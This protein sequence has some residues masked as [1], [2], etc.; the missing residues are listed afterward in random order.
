MPTQT[1]VK[2]IKLPYGLYEDAEAKNLVSKYIERADKNLELM[3]IVSELS[4]NKAAQKALSLPD[5][6]VNDEWVIIT[7]YY[8][9]YTGALALIAKLGYKSTMH[10]ATITALDKFFVKKELIEPHYLAMFKHA[11]TKISEKDVDTL[12]QEK[13]NRETAQYEVTKAVTHSI[14]EA[15][16]KNALDFVNKIKSIIL[17]GVKQ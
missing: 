5:N 13:E 16:K 7:A 14:A 8:S 11:H 17:E 10:A 3:N 9:M 4:T 12:S 6:Y 1:K 2:K 15:S